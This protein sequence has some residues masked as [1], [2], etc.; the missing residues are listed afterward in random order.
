MNRLMEGPTAH[1]ALASQSSAWAPQREQAQQGRGHCL[2]QSDGPRLLREMRR[3]EAVWRS[4]FAPAATTTEVSAPK[5]HPVLDG[6]KFE[7][8]AE[9]ARDVLGGKIFDV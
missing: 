4:R 5:H 9:A 2:L 8:F 6:V 7:T 1:S 3:G